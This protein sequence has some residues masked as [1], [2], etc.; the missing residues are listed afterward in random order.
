MN[1]AQKKQLF[2]KALVDLWMD[3]FNGPHHLC[4]LCG[5]YG[6]IDTLGQVQSP[7]GV[8]CGIRAFCICPNGRAMKLAGADM[9]AADKRRK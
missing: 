2:E 6:V 5:N 1:S 8:E 3:E 9:D 4:G 7:A